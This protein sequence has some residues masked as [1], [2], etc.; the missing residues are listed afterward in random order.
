MKELIK[1]IF[2]DENVPGADVFMDSYIQSKEN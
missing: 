1:A 2:G